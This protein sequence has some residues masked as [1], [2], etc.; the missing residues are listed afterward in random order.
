MK[1]VVIV[2]SHFAPSNLTGAHRARLLATYLPEFGWEPTIITVHER[3]YEEA[4][5]WELSKLLPRQ[6]VV[7][8]VWAIPTRPLRLIGDIGIRGFLGMYEEIRKLYAMEKLDFLYITIPSNY[9]AA[10][11]R[12][13]YHRLGISY[14]IDYIDPWVHEWPGAQWPLSKAWIS[15]KLARLLEPWAVKYARLITGIAPSYYEGVLSRNPHLKA[16]AVIVSMPYGIAESDYEYLEHHPRETFLFRKDD[17]KSHL[18][19]AGAMLPKAYPLLEILLRAVVHLIRNDPQGMENFRLHFIGTGKTPDDPQGYNIRPYIRKYGLEQWVEEHPQRIGYLDVL[20]HL[21]C[22]SAVLILGSTE[23]HYTPSKAFQAV[24]SGRPVLSILH[25]GST[26]VQFLA[27]TDAGITL[28]F[29]SDTLP[30]V[31]DVA[32]ALKALL[33]RK[34][35]IAGPMRWERIKPF[36][37]RHSARILADALHQALGERPR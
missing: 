13:V 32:Q 25:E 26:A 3:Y 10:L 37:A 30:S 18:V 31:E 1:Q 33:G 14:G 22:S 20:S 34:N 9:A 35:W 21:M 4:L 28:T 23:R 12:L 5:D 24:L 8:K 11:G 7:K 17:G 36:S 2:S 6:L 15:S 27:Q 16:Q 19:Y 29:K